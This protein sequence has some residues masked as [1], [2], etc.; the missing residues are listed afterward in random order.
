MRKRF[1][2]LAGVAVVATA[3]AL[4][5]LQL[6]ALDQRRARSGLIGPENFDRITVGMR[7]DEVEGILGGP[8][9]HFTTTDVGFFYPEGR[10]FGGKEEGWEYWS[11]DQ[12]EIEVVFD[13]QGGVRT[14]AL[15][16]SSF[17][18]PQSLFGH[19]QAWFRSLL[20]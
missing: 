13:E 15:Q 5:A 8:P 14:R 6:H 16:E 19:V 2:L 10:S 20:P 3:A 7:R 18:P 12:W 17:L 1:L 9:G 4:I 11:G